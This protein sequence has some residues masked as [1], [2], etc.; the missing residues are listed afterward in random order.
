MNSLVWLAVLF[1][2]AWLVLK[3]ALAVTSGLL[4]VLWIVAVIMFVLWL[5]GKVRG[6]TS[7]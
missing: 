3:L 7:V 6:K 2:V 5:I 4:H 1:I